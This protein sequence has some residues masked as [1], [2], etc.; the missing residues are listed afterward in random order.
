MGISGLLL[1]TAVPRLSGMADTLAAYQARAQLMGAIER[2]RFLALERGLPVTLCPAGPDGS[3]RPDWHHRLV[4]FSDPE[5]HYVVPEA[6]VTE[7]LLP[8]QASSVQRIMRPA[9]RRALQFQPDGTAPGMQGHL[10]LCPAGQQ[11]SAGRLVFS[12][13]GRTRFVSGD[14]DQRGCPQ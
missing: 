1:M 5:G 7:T 12:A 6:G 9:W 2:A 10:A 4:A 14:P 11:A 13:G 3:C 8:E